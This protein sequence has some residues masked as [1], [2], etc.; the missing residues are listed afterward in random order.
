MKDIIR[1]IAAAGLLVL[2]SCPR[3]YADTFKGEI[4]KLGDDKQSFTLKTGEAGE[5][6]EIQVWLVTE[7]KFKGMSSLA[8]V[9]KGDEVTVSAQQNAS[10]GHWEADQVELSKIVIHDPGAE[11]PVPKQIT[12]EKKDRIQEAEKSAA[13]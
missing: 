7:T 4:T 5:K 12:E 3:L 1:T 6:K 2:L 11:V 13:E 8:E 9:S 10:N